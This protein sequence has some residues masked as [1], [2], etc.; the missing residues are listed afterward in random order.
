MRFLYYDELTNKALEVELDRR[1]VRGERV[2]PVHIGIVLR[3]VVPVINDLN[4]RTS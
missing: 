1:N 3:R 4:I 2:G